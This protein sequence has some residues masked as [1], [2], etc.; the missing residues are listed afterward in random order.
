MA[1]HPNAAAGPASYGIQQSMLLPRLHH[2]NGNPCIHSRLQSCPSIAHGWLRHILPPGRH[3]VTP[4]AGD[5]A[6]NSSNNGQPMGF[7]QRWQRDSKQMQAQLQALGAAGVIAYGE[8]DC[9]ACL[10]ERV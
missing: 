1:L 7:I 3:V 5:A 2:I 8:T 6:G 4:A 9:Y 10:G